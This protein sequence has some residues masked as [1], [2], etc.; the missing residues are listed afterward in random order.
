VKILSN[1]C[2]GGRGNYKCK[3]EIF[4]INF[5]FGSI[6]FIPTSH[7]QQRHQRVRRQV[8]KVYFTQRELHHPKP[9]TTPSVTF[10][11]KLH[12]LR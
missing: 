1:E 5:N 9:N 4:K 10:H 11:I 8:P 12:F 3:K 2:E 7:Q 6:S